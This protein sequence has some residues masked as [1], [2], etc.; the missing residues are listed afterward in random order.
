MYNIFSR[1]VVSASTFLSM[2][3]CISNLNTILHFFLVS[4][5]FTFSPYVLELLIYKIFCLKIKILLCCIESVNCIYQQISY[6]CMLNTII[7]FNVFYCVY[8]FYLLLF[9]NGDIERNPGPQS[10]QIKNLS[11]FHWNVNSFVA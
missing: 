1:I 5:I 11:C 7:C 8:F 6:A 9:E 2:F 3:F 4:Y 10:G